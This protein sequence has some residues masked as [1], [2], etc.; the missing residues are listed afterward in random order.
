MPPAR[1]SIPQP[2]APTPETLL[3]AYPPAVQALAH[4]LHRVLGQSVP[5]VRVMAG[6]CVL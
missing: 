4:E 1:L 3:D 6:R 2:D 5:G